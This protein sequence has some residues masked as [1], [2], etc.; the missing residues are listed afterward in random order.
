MLIRC[1]IVR[2]PRL[3]R[4]RPLHSPVIYLVLIRRLL[5]NLS[6]QVDRKENELALAVSSED[7]VNLV[8]CLGFGLDFERSSL[9]LWLAVGRFAFLLWLR[10]KPFNE[11]RLSPFIPLAGFLVVLARW[12]F[13]FVGF[14]VRP[15]ADS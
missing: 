3:F 14:C 11:P 5:S 13:F 8:R 9:P 12:L 1:V 6:R 15:P 10:R 2:R 4:S 7:L